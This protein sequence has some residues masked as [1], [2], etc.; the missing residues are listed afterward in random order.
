VA[1]VIGSDVAALVEVRPALVGGRGDIV[2]PADVPRTWWVLLTPPFGV[3]AADAYRWWDED[4]GPPGSEPDALV[5]A[6]RSG[7]TERA[8]PLL[9]NDL[10]A[11]VTARHREVGE[12]RERLLEAGALGAVMV[13]SGP[14]VAGL[15]RD[16]FQA[17]DVAATTG[18]TATSAIT[19]APA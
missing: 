11:P 16:G 8:G 12:A 2:E 5:T 13:G 19:R 9:S 18:G 7:Q 15:V 14:T 1:V 4:G 3:R 17:E 6:L 10:E